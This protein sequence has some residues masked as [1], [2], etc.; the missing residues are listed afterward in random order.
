MKRLAWTAILSFFVACGADKLPEIP[1]LQVDGSGVRFMTDARTPFEAYDKAYSDL[2]RQHINIRRDLV[3]NGNRYAVESSAARIVHDLGIMKSVLVNP[4]PASLDPYIE[5]YREFEKLA[6]QNRV[7]GN[8]VTQLDQKQKEIK[9]KYAV[10]GVEVISEFPT[11][12]NE[13]AKNES[14]TEE[15]KGDD[16]PPP[17]EKKREDELPPPKEK[18]KEQE[19]VKKETTGDIPPKKNDGVTYRLLYKAWQKS[20]E[21]LC[22][23]YSARR[24]VKERYQEVAE[25][26]AGM[27]KLLV[28]K[29][30]DRLQVYVAFYEKVHEDTKGFT[31]PPA[32]AKDE[33]VLNDL[34]IVAAGIAKDF[35]PAR[36]K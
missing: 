1:T 8:W 14:K 30:A 15:K 20:H 18:E 19:P 11:K 35:D 13:T 16:L 3:P 22:A 25:A 21:D 27:K 34:K 33:D 4:E 2:T 23:A 10:S 26:L 6:K 36:R 31:S 29:E 32:G 12:K 24:E 5:F 9:L 7:A 28:P 17:K